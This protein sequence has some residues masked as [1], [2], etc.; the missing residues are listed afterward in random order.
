MFSRKEFRE[1]FEV[2][3][4][5]KDITG[6]YQEIA[7][8]RMNQLKSG[9]E[10]TRDF[11]NG[12]AEVYNHAKA[13]YIANL[14][15]T[16][17]G[18]TKPAQEPKFI[19]RNG[20]TVF[21][22]LT[23]NEHLYGNL[24]LNV[25]NQFLTDLKTDNK[26]EAVI[27]GVFGRYLMKNEKGDFKPTYFDLNDDRPT[28]EQ[29]NKIIDYIS[30]YEQIIV[31][32]GQLVSVLEQVATS[33]SISG[34]VPLEQK[35]DSAKRYLFE[36][37]PEKIMEFFETEIISA[38]FIQKIYEHELA[39][40]ASRTVAMDQAT[41]NANEMLKKLNRDFNT[42]RKATLNRKQQQVFAG[43]SLWG[44]KNE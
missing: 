17:L 28:K 6:I 32:H 23:A 14:Q 5:I 37:S 34:G 15:K 29:I 12:V 11:L 20:K 9:V 8:M 22:C 18:G 42:L 4:A 16:P 38:L 7:L 10:K 43:F 40:F 41:Q 30:K 3:S 31:S 13:A 25:W 24:I 36:P 35:M 26:N 33:A 27:V 44:G 1:N 2:V 39:K 19:K 21:V